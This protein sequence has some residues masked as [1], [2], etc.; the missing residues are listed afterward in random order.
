MGI[1]QILKWA[2]ADFWLGDKVC[3]FI[4]RQVTA[5]FLIKKRQITGKKSA[6]TCLIKY[7]FSDFFKKRY[8]PSPLCSFYFFFFFFGLAGDSNRRPRA[9][10]SDTLSSRLLGL[11]LK[12]K[13][14]IVLTWCGGGGGDALPR[15]REF[16]NA[17]AR[18][19][20]HAHAHASSEKSASNCGTF[21]LKL[22][23]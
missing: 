12:K 10:K 23:K 5:N 11:C 6:S 2:F 18:S 4:N 21:L 16:V 7:A 3:Q 22:G 17:Y 20:A 9:P 8:C 1:Y 15:A 13:G 19:H 14:K